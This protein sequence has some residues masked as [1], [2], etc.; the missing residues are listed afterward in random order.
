MVSVV[1]PTYNRVGMMKQAVESVLRQTYK[2]VE[3]VIVDDNSTDDTGVV[4]KEL[5]SKGYNILYYKNANNMGPGY[6]RNKGYCL[7]S[8]EYVVFMDDDD[9]YTDD[10]FYEKA[11]SILDSDKKIACVSAN[12][13]IENVKE[14]SVT[15]ADIGF[16]GKKIGEEYLLGLNKQYHKPLSTFA[17][18]F[19]KKYLEQAELGSMKMVN[20]IAIYMRAL[21]FGDIYV[22]GDRIGNYRVHGNNISARIEKDF[23]IDNMKERLWTAKKFK[24][25]LKT[26]NQWLNEQ[27]LFCFSYYIR[28]THPTV[29]DCWMIILW[30]VMNSKI[31]VELYKGI[32]RILIKERKQNLH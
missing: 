18:V 27:L 21:V 32:L 20:D 28:G 14:H 31:S 10:T 15:P 16:E 1:M 12:A 13:W 5:A 9:Y 22:I 17:T 3:I 6:N 7:S 30:I 26:A 11:I 24:C 25:D 19:S 8:G 29:I 4:V 2:N 23:L